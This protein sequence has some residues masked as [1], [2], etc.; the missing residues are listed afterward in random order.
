MTNW[1]AEVEATTP[2][3][4]QLPQ[5]QAR[6]TARLPRVSS[7]FGYRADPLRGK[8]RMHS[9]IDIP[10]PLGTPIQ[11]SAG[12]F[13]RFAGSAGG[14]GQMIE[15][16]HGNG[17]TTRY[18]HLSR[19]LV[20]PGAPIAR[21]ETIALMGSTGRSTGS[22]LHFEVRDSGRPADPLAYLGGAP[23]ETAGS[24]RGGSYRVWHALSEPH[25]SQF[26]RARAAA[27]PSAEK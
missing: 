14:Y 5:A 10:A 26:A 21:G 12:G 18:A 25:V 15:I 6:T 4:V 13:V 3:V 11:A 24:F 20:Q 17:L 27:E 8:V 16:A 7:R 1:S 22:H 23:L 9:G 19:I 2:V